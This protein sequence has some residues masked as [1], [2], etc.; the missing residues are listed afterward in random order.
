M[1]SSAALEQESAS[2]QV[3]DTRKMLR[4]MFDSYA[5]NGNRMTVDTIQSQKYH[6][7]MKEAGVYG[8]S[9]AYTAQGQLSSSDKEM[10]NRL[11]LIFCS[12]NRSKT[13][14]DFEHFLQSLV[15]VAE[16]KFPGDHPSQ[17]LKALMDHHMIPLAVQTIQKQ[18]SQTMGI[19]R[20]DRSSR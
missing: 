18:E 3:V 13:N 19:D 20:G 14:M 1:A 4:S 10:K 9:Q 7:L 5:L 15:K 16:A 12:V 6:R 11:D 17:G 8:Q 2:Q